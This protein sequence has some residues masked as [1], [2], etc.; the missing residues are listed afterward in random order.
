MKKWILITLA[1]VVLL[2]GGCA[3]TNQPVGDDGE[4]PP[5]AQY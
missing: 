2:A 1:V 5:P 4:L 3:T